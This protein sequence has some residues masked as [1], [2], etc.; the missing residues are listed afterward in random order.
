MGG[1]GAGEHLQPSPAQPLPYWTSPLLPSPAQ[2]RPGL[3]AGGGP[4]GGGRLTR[5]KVLPQNPPSSHPSLLCLHPG[6]ALIILAW[7]SAVS[8]PLVPG[9]PSLLHPPPPVCRPC[10]KRQ[11]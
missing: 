11:Q 10:S 2:N 1:G 9:L 7:T 8:S 4:G 3:L 6:P 5:R